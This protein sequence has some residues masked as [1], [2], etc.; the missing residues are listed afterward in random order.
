MFAFCW[1]WVGPDIA[2]KVCAPSVTLSI[3]WSCCV[4]II[5]SEKIHQSWLSNFYVID[6]WNSRSNIRA[7]CRPFGNVIVLTK[8]TLDCW[9][10]SFGRLRKMSILQHVPWGIACRICL[11]NPLTFCKMWKGG[12]VN[13]KKSNP[14]W[15]EIIWRLW[16]C[17]S[18]HYFD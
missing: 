15:V 5:F 16:Q 13:W 11:I 4:V 3:L 10:F 17:R 6:W 12:L 7:P 8:N 18:L 2:W 9:I 14:C 1:R